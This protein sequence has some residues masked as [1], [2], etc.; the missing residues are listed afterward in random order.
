MPAHAPLVK[1]MAT[2]GYGATVILHGENFAQ[3]YAHARTLQAATGATFIHAFDD[4]HLIAGQGTL[5][6]EV[7]SQLPSVDA[8][9]VPLDEHR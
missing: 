4:H 9:I 5:G 2:R 8:I 1:V 7:L 3:A 6:L